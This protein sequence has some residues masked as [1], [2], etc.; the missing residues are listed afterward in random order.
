MKIIRYLS[1]AAKDI[2][3]GLL[4]RDPLQRL[5]SS[6]LDATEVSTNQTSMQM[7]SECTSSSVC[8]SMYIYLHA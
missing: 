5:G 8:C 7:L 6:T 4:T 3:H 2:L 1:E